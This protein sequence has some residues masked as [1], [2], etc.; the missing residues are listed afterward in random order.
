VDP[1]G[2]GIL[3][4][5]VL[6]AHIWCVTIPLDAKRELKAVKLPYNAQVHIF[7]LTLQ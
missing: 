3:S 5:E 6:A 1:N 2:Q 4:K 7:A